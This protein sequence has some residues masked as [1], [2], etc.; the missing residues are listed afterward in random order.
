MKWKTLIKIMHNLGVNF[1]N[2]SG[3]TNSLAVVQ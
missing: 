3:S 2:S 1:S